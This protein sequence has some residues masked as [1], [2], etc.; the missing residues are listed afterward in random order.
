MIKN[1]LVFSE[2]VSYLPPYNSINRTYL[3]LAESI[4]FVD[5]LDP[6]SLPP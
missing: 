2:F 1:S 5:I 6:T 4:I 3:N